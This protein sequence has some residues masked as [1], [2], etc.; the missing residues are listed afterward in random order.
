VTLSYRDLYLRAWRNSDVEQAL[1]PHEDIAP[2]F[3]EA[4][5]GAVIE[6]Q[7]LPGSV[8]TVWTPDS[9]ETPLYAYT[10]DL[11]GD[12]SPDRERVAELLADA[13]VGTERF[14]DLLDGQKASFDTGN[15]RTPDDPEISGNY[16]V[17]GGRTDD[18]DL[19]L[20]DIDVD[21]YDEAKE[22]NPR[23]EAL[24]G[25]TLGVASAHTTTDRPGHL[26]VAV[27]GDAAAI[28]QDVLGREVD[29]PAASFGEIR[30][31]NQYVVGPGSEIVCGCEL[32]DDPDTADH[33]GRYEIA[34]ERPPV[35]WSAEEFRAF[36]EAD[37]AIEPD[38]GDDEPETED[39]SG[40]SSSGGS[41]GSV[42]LDDA[43]ERVQ[44]AKAVDDHVAN[45]FREARS[46]DD[47][48]SSADS[49]LARTLAPWLGYDEDDLTDVL[50]DHGTGKW[51]NRGDSYRSSVL[52]YAR[53][54]DTDAYETIPYWAL[55][56]AAVRGDIVSEDRLVER[57]S[58][59][60]EVVRGLEAEEVD[61]YRALPPGSYNTVLMHVEQTY[62]ID[63][64]RDPVENSET[65]TAS[66]FGGVE[67]DPGKAAEDFL[68]MLEVSD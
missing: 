10:P 51:A 46:P 16:G 14:I 25:E 43:D 8:W 31:K 45:A 48:R 63:T 36:L 35:V 21:D 44:F 52:S 33:Y 24:R 38:S 53:D 67:D 30:V 11:A 9:R 61:T 2:V 6:Q 47:D 64:G 58:E 42:S 13:G 37:P 32:C 54:R 40:G 34:T 56:E 26:Y 3:R 27:D 22:S 49:N 41:T 28:A 59:T 68:K 20:V 39:T 50:D 5:Y 29:N 66:E 60:G 18:S 23:V 65:P 4:G 7:R 57:D 55:V 15:D 17:K 12:T 62:D 1:I 19:W